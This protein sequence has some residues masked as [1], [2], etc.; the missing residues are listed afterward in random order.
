MMFLCLPNRKKCVTHDIKLM[1]KNNIHIYNISYNWPG[2]RIQPGQHT[3]EA[4]ADY[5]L[6]A[7]I[8]EHLGSPGQ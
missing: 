3:I 8:K 5:R 6:K 4:C 2:Q 1:Y 7:T